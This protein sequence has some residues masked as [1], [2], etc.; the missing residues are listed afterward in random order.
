MSTAEPPVAPAPSSDPTRPG[1][2]R[3]HQPWRGFVALGEAVLAAAAT[4]VGV[5]CWHRGVT[6]MV[7]PLGPGQP[8]L[9]STI[10][11][12]GWMAAGIGLITVAAFLV[13]DAVRQALL[14]V[15]TRRRP[16]PPL[17]TVAEP[18]TAAEPD[19]AG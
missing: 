14:A 12:G 7:T 8:P 4:V 6:T 11:Y 19:P 18:T 1:P 5:L 15:R 3:L 13:L 2:A 17:V 16:L 9:V 10:F